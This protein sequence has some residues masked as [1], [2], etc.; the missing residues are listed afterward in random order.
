MI[1]RIFVSAFISSC[2]ILSIYG[3]MRMDPAKRVEELKEQLNLT[4]EQADQITT[5]FTD[6]DAKMKELFENGDP[7]DES[8]RE[9]MDSLRTENEEAIMNILTEEQQTEYKKIVEE[10]E[11][12]M[13]EHRPPQMN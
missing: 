3:Q 12:R 2:L 1:K 9:K 13:K 7:R 4:T 6:L 10:R 8:T 11:K 5:I